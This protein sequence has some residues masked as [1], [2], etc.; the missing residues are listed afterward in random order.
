[1]SAGGFSHA[2]SVVASLPAAHHLGP[3]IEEAPGAKVR[4]E[5]EACQGAAVQTLREEL[6]RLRFLRRVRFVALLFLIGCL[7]ISAVAAMVVES[8]LGVSLGLFGSGLGTLITLVT[9]HT[10][11][12][13]AAIVSQ[14]DIVKATNALSVLIDY[15]TRAGKG[16]AFEEV[17]LKD[18]EAELKASREKNK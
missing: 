15:S 3:S 7:T 13:E 2:I 8:K 12:H 17:V 4:R 14:T 6:E 9:S 1:M 11:K 10:G 16:E 18:I 5:L